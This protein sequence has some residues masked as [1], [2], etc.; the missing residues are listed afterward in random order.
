MK[1]DSSLTQK[2]FD[3]LLDWLDPDRERAGRK[4]LDIRR[5]LVKFFLNKQCVQAEELTDETINR[6]A[7]KAV[8]LKDNYEGEP[9]K[10]FYAF[11]RNV[12]HED[13]RARNRKVQPPP[14]PSP[15]EI[16]PRA[17]CMGICLASLPPES[18]E[19]V[20]RYYL[21]HK[22]GKA[23]SHKELAN[24]MGLSEGALRARI[25]RLRARL[26][27]C[28]E[29]CSMNTAQS[30]DMDSTAIIETESGSGVT[31]RSDEPTK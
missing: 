10:Y 29:E 6:V 4:L 21:E 17:K 20:L 25:H 3:D 12:C 2:K 22:T 5:R 19:L 27:A 28:V 15:K 30:N 7:G 14:A 9:T 8:G 13:Y 31:E 16:D 26:K 18:R 11:A 1:T 23:A 24:S